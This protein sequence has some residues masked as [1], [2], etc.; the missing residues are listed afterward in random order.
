MTVTRLCYRSTPNFATMTQSLDAE[1]ERLL[2]IA[3]R[4]NKRDGITGALL[5]AGT[6]FFQMIEGPRSCVM[7]T[8][9]RIQDDP[10]HVD[11][12][13]IDERD[14]ANRLVPKNPLFF[15]DT[16]DA[17]DGVLASLTLP[18]TQSPDLVD[19]ADLASLLLFSA[20]RAARGDWRAN[21][22][23]A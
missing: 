7:R 6:T 14:D 2:A 16:M 20:N 3:R 23:N 10:R 11:L 9:T 15:A 12:R 21:A 1:I 17:Y 22:L 5:I 18:I 19:Y 4:N 8:F 13:V